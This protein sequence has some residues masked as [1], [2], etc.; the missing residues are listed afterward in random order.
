VGTNPELT[1]HIL[2]A[3][4]VTLPTYGQP[5][6]PSLTM[7]RSAGAVQ[8]SWPP[9][10]SNFVLQASA[11]LQAGSWTNLASTNNSATVEATNTAQLFRVVLP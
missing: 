8:I 6:A 11:T 4:R 10:F 9:A 5:S 7:Q 1:D 2:L 3:Y